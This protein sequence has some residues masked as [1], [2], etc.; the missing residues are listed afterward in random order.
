MTWDQCIDV[1][2]AMKKFFMTCIYPYMVLEGPV[3]EARDEFRVER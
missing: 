3:P 1:D 2:T